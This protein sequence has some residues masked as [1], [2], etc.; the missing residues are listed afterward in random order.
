MALLPGDVQ[1]AVVAD[2]Q[3]LIEAVKANGPGRFVPGPRTHPP[4]G[5]DGVA[6][7]DRCALFKHRTYCAHTSDKVADSFPAAP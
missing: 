1:A 2:L 4:N 3:P 6:L 5:E 7:F